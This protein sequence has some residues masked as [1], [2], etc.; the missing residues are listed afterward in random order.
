METAGRTHFVLPFSSCGTSSQDVIPIRM[1]AM[2][3]FLVTVGTC[4]EIDIPVAIRE[5][6]G[7]VE[8]TR[9]VFRPDGARI[10]VEIEKNG[11]SDSS[12]NE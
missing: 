11:A 1:Q 10:I 5:S 3:E 8:G 4:G 12:L 6:L 2:E 7:I 9:L